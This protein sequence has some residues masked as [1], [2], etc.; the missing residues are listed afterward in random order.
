MKQNIYDKFESVNKTYSDL[1]PF[2]FQIE[3]INNMNSAY[4]QRFE[5]IATSNEVYIKF[6]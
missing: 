3:A 6:K 2:N 4:K 1:E 5:I